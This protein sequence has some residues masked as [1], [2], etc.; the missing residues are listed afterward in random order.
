CRARIMTASNIKVFLR[1]RPSAKPSA[2]FQANLEQGTVTFD[3][4]KGLTDHEINNN[5]TQHSYRFDG[6]MGMKTSQEDVLSTVAKPVIEDVM[7]GVNG[8]IFAYGQ[9]GSG[10]TFTITGGASNYADRGLIPRSIQWMFEAFR[11]GDAQYRMYISYFE[12]YQD[13]GYDLLRDDSVRQL[14]DLPKVELREDEDGNMHLR[15]LSVNLA[16]SEE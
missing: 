8:T 2:G 5:K 11:K 13:K 9:T 3:L 15:N 7:N 12:I 10:K 16:A 1:V 14:E 4:D 6:V